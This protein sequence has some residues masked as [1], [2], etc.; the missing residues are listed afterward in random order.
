MFK[1]STSLATNACDFLVH[2]G[3]EAAKNGGSQK[4][5]PSGEAE[6]GAV[7]HNDGSDEVRDQR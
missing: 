3:T 6:V 7:I 1:S 4:W 5:P 2:E